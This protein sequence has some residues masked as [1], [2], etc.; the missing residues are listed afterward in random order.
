MKKTIL[1][2]LVYLLVFSLFV[3]YAFFVTSLEWFSNPTDLQKEIFVE[4]A[5]GSFIFF[6]LMFALED[7]FKLLPWD[8]I[9]KKIFKI[10]CRKN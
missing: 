6:L 5:L 1:T 9:R 8:Q 2:I 4:G 3:G 10:Y 7:L